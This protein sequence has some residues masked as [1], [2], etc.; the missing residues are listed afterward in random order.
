MRFLCHTEA[1]WVW[2]TRVGVTEMQYEKEFLSDTWNPSTK[3]SNRCVLVLLDISF[4][5]FHFFFDKKERSRC[6]GLLSALWLLSPWILSN[7]FI[8]GDAT[9]TQNDVTYEFQPR[10]HSDLTWCEKKDAKQKEM[11][12]LKTGWPCTWYD[13]EGLNKSQAA[14]ELVRNN[15]SKSVLL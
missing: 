11:N 14:W 12:V 1:Q 10:C 7:L 13:E 5:G 8:C 2:T 6:Y 15:V 4:C 3:V 9:T